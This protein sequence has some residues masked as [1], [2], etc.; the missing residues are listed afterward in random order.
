[1]FSFTLPTTDIDGNPIN[2]EN[3]SYSIFI[4]NDSL[5]TFDYFYYYYDL[6]DDMSVIPYSIYSNGYDITDHA[7]YL[8]GTNYCDW[9]I[10]TWRIGIQVYYTVGSITNESDIV[11]LEV[12]PNPSTAVGEVM[13]N[14][15]VAD[16]RYYNMAGQEVAQ[17]QGMAIKVTTYTDGTTSSVKVVK[18]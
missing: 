6:E 18:N 10:F 1:M 2:P 9:P 15:S 12:F 3:L 13:A 16:V 4:D 5:Y 8:Y 11:Y 7:V 14:K 17:P